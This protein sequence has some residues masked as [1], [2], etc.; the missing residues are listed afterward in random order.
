MIFNF[1]Q[2]E[3][4]AFYIHPVFGIPLRDLR[5]EFNLK[6]TYFSCYPEGNEVVIKGRGFGHG[7]GLCQEGAMKMARSG[8]DFEQIMKFYF[9]GSDVIHFGQKSYFQ[10]PGK[11]LLLD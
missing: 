11:L 1:E 5:E 7:V 4:K 6:S 8:L 10:Q 9:P 3:R 2:N